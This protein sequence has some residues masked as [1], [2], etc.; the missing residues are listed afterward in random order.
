MPN[1]LAGLAKPGIAGKSNSGPK[2]LE[3]DGNP[4]ELALMSII[5]PG[6]MGLTGCLGPWFSFLGFKTGLSLT[7]SG[8]AKEVL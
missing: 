8:V 7:T 4:P 6:M 3:N 1:P 2:G 5:P